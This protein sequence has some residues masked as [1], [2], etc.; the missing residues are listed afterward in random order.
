[1]KIAV[2]G[3]MHGEL[4]KTYE[5]VAEIEEREGFKVELVIFFHSN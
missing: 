4:E 5:T 1:M 3:C 2:V